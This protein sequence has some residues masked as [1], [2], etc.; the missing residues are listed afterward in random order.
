M[1]GGCLGEMYFFG[2][3]SSRPL[4]VLCAW[5][6]LVIYVEQNDFLGDRG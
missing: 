1:E 6:F 2:S 4:V 5:S 3:S